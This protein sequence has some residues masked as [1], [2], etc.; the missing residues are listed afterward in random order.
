MKMISMNYTV[1]LVIDPRVHVPLDNRVMTCSF[2]L[3]N[4]GC[5]KRPSAAGGI[6]V[7]VILIGERPSSRESERERHPSTWAEKTAHPGDKGA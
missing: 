6:S 5:K 2:C 1:Q 3:T 7:V 4:Y